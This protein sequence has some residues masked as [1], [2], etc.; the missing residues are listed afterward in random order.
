MSTLRK[1]AESGVSRMRSILSPIRKPAGIPC[2]LAA[3]GLMVAAPCRCA[4]G[5]AYSPGLAVSR[6][7]HRLLKNPSRLQLV[8]SPRSK[9]TFFLRLRFCMAGAHF[10]AAA[11]I[12]SKK[13]R[14][15]VAA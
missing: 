12:A 9:E 14:V 11:L 8:G 2:A 4:A 3:F 10:S 13:G 15:V 5:A 7:M 1:F 6:I